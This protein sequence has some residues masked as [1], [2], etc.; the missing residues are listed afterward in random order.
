MASTWA[1]D[2]KRDGSAART[3]EYETKTTRAMT[4]QELVIFTVG[5]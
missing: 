3:G 5:Y 4:R 2:G 1:L